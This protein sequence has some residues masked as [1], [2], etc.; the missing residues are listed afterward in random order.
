MENGLVV[1]EIW[2]F[3]W[4]GPLG[5]GLRLGDFWVFFET[6]RNSPGLVFGS[7][8]ASEVSFE[9]SWRALSDKI[10]NKFV[11]GVYKKLWCL[12]YGHFWH[13]WEARV[14]FCDFFFSFFCFHWLVWVMLSVGK[15]L[16]LLWEFFF[17]TFLYFL[18]R[19][20]F[21]FLVVKCNADLVGC[22][23]V[24]LFWLLVYWTENG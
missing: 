11:W 21:E 7:Y 17:D 10:R 6:L 2:W 9:S 14:F 5:L 23:V 4:F 12:K 15:L 1:A 3:F 22:F 16:F 18:F 8:E 19:Y 20:F 24:V 13:F